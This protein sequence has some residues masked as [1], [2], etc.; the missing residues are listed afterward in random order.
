MCVSV[1][2]SL[3]FV[4]TRRVDQFPSGVDGRGGGHGSRLCATHELLSS[5]LVCNAGNEQH[6]YC[7]GG[8]TQSIAAAFEMD[9]LLSVHRR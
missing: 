9:L 1:Q 3:A 4:S 8:V 6:S 2:H 7:S 5:I